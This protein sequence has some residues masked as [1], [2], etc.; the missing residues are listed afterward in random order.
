MDD[1]ENAW[2]SFCF[3]DYSS[4][5]VTPKT[6]KNNRGGAIGAGAGASGVGA[7]AKCTPLNIS[8]KTKISYLNYPI[9]L[10]DVFWK[11]P[12][13]NYFTPTNGVI[14]KQM[15]FNSSTPEEVDEIIKHKER[16]TH[17]DDY[18]ISQVTNTDGRNKF[19]DTRKV[20]IGI[21]KK[22]IISY[23]SKKKSAFYNCFVVIL[24]LL[25]NDIYKEVH[26][27]VFNTGKLEIPGI[28]DSTIL[29]KTL[30]LL[31]DIL[32]PFIK[33]EQ[34]DKPLAFLDEKTET[35]MINSNFNCG[36]YINR[37]SMYK[38]LKYTYLINSNF[39]SCSYP[40]IQCEFYYN[41]ENE[42]HM[43]TGTQPLCD[44]KLKSDKTPYTPTTIKV[45]FMIFRTGSVLIV[46]KC[47]EKI[48]YNIY[49][50]LCNIFIKNKE[51]IKAYDINKPAGAM[52]EVE[53]KREQPR[54]IR[55]KTIYV[56]A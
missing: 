4:K 55:K 26:V 32:T 47:S 8:T 6:D 46:G 38:L 33:P 16:Y 36:Y 56:D 22:D 52:D 7:G 2:S 44:K 49:D 1:I 9:P 11:I 5:N 29:N 3:S 54:K 15:K 18:I 28:Q 23:R 19:K 17:V 41:D 27:K 37:E 40:G 34:D 45:S 48:L 39:D 43:Q 24:R 21:C 30:Q 25:H 14:K 12:I 35:V 10:S 31:V 50:F 53:V 20:S 13:I 42:F 51:E